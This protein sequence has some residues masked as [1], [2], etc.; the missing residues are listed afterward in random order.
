MSEPTKAQLQE[1]L[2][3]VRA[4]LK[5]S[6]RRIDKLDPEAKALANVVRALDQLPSASRNTSSYALASGPNPDAV[7]RVLEAAARR[8]GI[9]LEY[10]RLIAAVD[11]ARITEHERNELERLRAW[12]DSNPSSGVAW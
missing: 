2:A 1:E 4:L 7:R 3:R 5:E 9:E 8:F 12:A 10:H 11:K 6:E